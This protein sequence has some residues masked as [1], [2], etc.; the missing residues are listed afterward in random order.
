MGGFKFIDVNQ[1]S[2][3]WFKLRAGMLTSSKLGVIMANFGKSFGE[4]AKKYAVQIASEQITGDPISSGYSNEHMDRGHQQ[5]PI[6]R[7]L[8]EE[9]SFCD[10]GN[11]GFF[12]SD[13]V[14]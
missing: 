10:V 3:E 11:G 6:A 4:P 8:Y 7:M 5:E 9:Q 14:S 2:D 13:F 12:H 1:N